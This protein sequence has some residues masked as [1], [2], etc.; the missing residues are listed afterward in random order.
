MAQ[1]KKNEKILNVPNTLTMLRA[2]LIPVYWAV[3]MQGHHYWALAIFI[4]ASLTDLADGYIARKYDLI[5]DFG[6]LMDPFADKL[7]VLSV[8]LSLALMGMA[9]WPAL[10]IILAKE[11]LMVLGGVILAQP[12]RN[13]RVTG[14][15]SIIG[16]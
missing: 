13:A 11:L 5:T 1:E 12:M 16:L 7:M 14:R 8:M 10:A 9:P 15:K 3:F 2:L 4:V 6:K